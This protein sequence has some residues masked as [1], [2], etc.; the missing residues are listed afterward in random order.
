LEVQ[1]WSPLSGGIFSGKE[2]KPDT[3]KTI[4]ETKEYVYKLAEEK[5]KTP[6][7]IVLAFILKHP[8]QIRPV[9][10]TS[11]AERRG[12]HKRIKKQSSA[13]IVFLILYV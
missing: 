7:C 13:P 9:I 8:A 3:D 6:E 5:N 1:A 10:G 2:L 12:C 11:K 4:L